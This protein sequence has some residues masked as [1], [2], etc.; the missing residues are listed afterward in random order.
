M[1]QKSCLD[2][3]SLPPGPFTTCPSGG[4]V[5]IPWGEVSARMEKDSVWVRSEGKPSWVLINKEGK[6]VRALRETDT[7]WYT[8]WGWM[9][10]REVL[11]WLHAVLD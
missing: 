1:T 7:A 11:D 9:P 2:W 3:E 10:K 4:Y 8:G 5:P 6:V